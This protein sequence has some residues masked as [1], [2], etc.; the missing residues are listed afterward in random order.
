MTFDD[1]IRLVQACTA[2]VAAVAWPLVVLFMLVRFTPAL[3]DFLLDLGELSFKGGGFEAS[4]RRVKEEVKAGLVAAEVGR[5]A[6]AAPAPT[7]RQASQAASA[8]T[9]A[10]ST[11]TIRRAQGATALWVDDRPDNNR[12]ERQS[13]ETLG[14]S[15]VLATSTEEALRETARRKFDVIISDMGRPPDSRAG[16]TLLRALRERGDTTPY[17]I[18]A[19]SNA[20]A[21]QEEA[22]RAGALGATNR[23]SEL[24]V[25]VLSALDGRA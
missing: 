23:A 18:Y 14:M 5:T 24:F 9:D 3:K 25:L 21:H 6:E 2:L 20:A 1:F 15:F 7:L 22:R 8:A 10:V 12:L 11:R 4:A 19:G 13:F 16:Y 17:V